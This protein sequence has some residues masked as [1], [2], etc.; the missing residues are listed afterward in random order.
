[1]PNFSLCLLLASPKSMDSLS[2]SESLE[3]KSALEQGQKSGR[4]RGTR[5]EVVGGTEQPPM[6][7][8]DATRAAEIGDF[9]I[10]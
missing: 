4:E 5:V 8:G 9:V 3:D 6:C 10:S 2:L 1:M 7:Y